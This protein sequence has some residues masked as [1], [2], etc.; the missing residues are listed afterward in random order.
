[1]DITELLRLG[2]QPSRRLET[3]LG[4][5]AAIPYPSRGRASSGPGARP[6]GETDDPIFAADPN[7]TTLLTRRVP[8]LELR[9]RQSMNRDRRGLAASSDLPALEERLFDVDER[10]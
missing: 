10:T 8:L 9:L 6:T 5:G 2:E 7:E 4:C 1:L 3:N